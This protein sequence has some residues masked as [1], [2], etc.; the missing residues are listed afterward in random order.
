MR[1]MRWSPAQF[2]QLRRQREQRVFRTLSA[3]SSRS[4]SG[5]RAQAH[6]SSALLRPASAE[7]LGLERRN[8]ILHGAIAIQDPNLVV[9]G[10]VLVNV[11]DIPG[12]LEQ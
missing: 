5:P 3:A 11:K 2:V 9:G 12:L 1:S 6:H 4:L 10:I 8:W 7:R